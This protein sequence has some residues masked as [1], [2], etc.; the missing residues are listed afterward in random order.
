MIQDIVHPVLDRQGL[1]LHGPVEIVFCAVQRELEGLQQVPEIQVARQPGIERFHAVQVLVRVLRGRMVEHVG[2]AVLVLV[3]HA[4]RFL[5]L[6]VF[7]QALH[8]FFPRVRAFLFLLFGPAGQEHLR[9]D[10]Q[11]RRRH[12]Q[13]LAADF[14]IEQFEQLEILKVLLRDQRDGNIVDIHLV[15]PD[16]EQQEV[17]RSFEV[18][19][20]YLVGHSNSSGCSFFRNK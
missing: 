3:Q 17:Q 9:L 14:E 19:E 18:F 2:V 16:Q 10:A 8:E 4:G 12:E 20:P 5:E 1:P 15:F 11:E 6:P 7:Q 13:V